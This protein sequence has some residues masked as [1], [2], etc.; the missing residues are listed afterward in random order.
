MHLPT[1][2]VL[3][4]TA[5]ALLT[6]T[7]C[8]GG[9]SA[10][11]AAG[12]ATDADGEAVTLRYLIEQPEEATSLELWE[13]H[14]DEFEAAN[15]GITVELE[16]MPL[17]NMRTVLQTQ[18]RSG[19]GPDVFNWGSGPGYAGAL[20]EAG[21]LYD[22][23]GAY[24]DY[25]WP[26]YDFAKERVTFDGKIVGVPG[27]METV[28]IFYNKDVFTELGL[29]EPESLADL[30]QAARAIKDANIIPFAVSDQ[31]G[32]QGGHYLS[33]ALSSS[34]GSEGMQA[35]IDGERPWTAPEVVEALQLWADW[36]DAGYF[37]PYPTS[38]SYDAGN[39]LFYSGE[40]AMAPTGSWAIDGITANTDFEV[41]YLPFPAEDGPGI[42]VGG[43]GSGP[44]IAAETAHPEEA[45]TF[46]DFLASQEHGQW[47]VEELGVIPAW[48]VDTEG[49]EASPLFA[50]VLEDT[51]AFST[52]SADLGLNID[53]LTTDVFNE[54]MWDGV[55]ALLSEQAAAQD[56]AE[57]LEAAAGDD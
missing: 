34:V 29:D 14:I 10:T 4:P 19:D 41:G 23:T 35:L 33:M 22:L 9:T 40:A 37:P 52:G 3:T 45:L 20:A 31:E 26:V 47:M 8:T 30:E 7:A 55:Q 39:A 16:A 13:E 1:F 50:Q 53:V 36:Y 12:N 6:L 56:V 44:F 57:Q 11:E 2:R 5:A 43:L 27:D 17:E 15:P 42:F 28:G 38:L 25:G 51:A 46:L 24:E 32:W 49:V 48:P 54:A 18:L 21:V